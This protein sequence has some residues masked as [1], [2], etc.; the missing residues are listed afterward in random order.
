MK[1]TLIL[2]GESEA[3][4]NFL[5]QIFHTGLIGMA[6][7]TDEENQQIESVTVELP[8]KKEFL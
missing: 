3:D 4:K 5:H 6:A 1:V 2:T 7:N 8:T